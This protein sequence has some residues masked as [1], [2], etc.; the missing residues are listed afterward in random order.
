MVTIRTAQISAPYLV[1]CSVEGMTAARRHLER[2][3]EDLNREFYHGDKRVSIYRE[4]GA[5]APPADYMTPA[6]DVP[7][8]FV[9]TE[10]GYVPSVDEIA[11]WIRL[12]DSD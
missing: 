6:F 1:I 5:L 7:T 2:G 12:S 3:L 9:S 8:L 4:T 11:Q 10:E